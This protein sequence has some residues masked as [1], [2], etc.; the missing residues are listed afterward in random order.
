MGVKLNVK[1]AKN[2]TQKFAENH[3]V[4]QKLSTNKLFHL[5]LIT[6]HINPK[7]DHENWYDSLLSLE[8]WF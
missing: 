6:R 4:F 7:T 2:I 5:T 3:K 8:T 1:V